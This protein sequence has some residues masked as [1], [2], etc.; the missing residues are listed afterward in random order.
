APPDDVP[1][2]EE[3]TL[4]HEQ[5]AR[6]LRL[7]QPQF[8][9][10]DLKDHIDWVFV[11]PWNAHQTDAIAIWVIKSIPRANA[12]LRGSK[13]ILLAIV[14]GAVVLGFGGLMVV[15]GDLRRRLRQIRLG[16]DR[17]GYD[18]SYRLPDMSGEFG[19]I[20]GSVNAMSMTLSRLKSTTELILE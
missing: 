10:Q 20:T 4:V 13:K 1:D 17:L 11:A 5:I 14:L 16:L 12:P 15:I 7:G 2:P 19:E 8:V 6:A 3:R 9:T 18:L